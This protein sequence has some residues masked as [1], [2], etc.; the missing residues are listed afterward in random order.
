MTIYSVLVIHK[1]WGIIKDD[2]CTFSTLSKAREY[3]KEYVEHCL[4]GFVT[5]EGLRV[6]NFSSDYTNVVILATD[7]E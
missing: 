1:E 2:T 6:G 5:E 3:F 4:G 7:V